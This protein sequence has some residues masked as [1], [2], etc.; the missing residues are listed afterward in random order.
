MP[1][2][3]Q[4]SKTSKVYAVFIQKT[5]PHLPFSVFCLDCA[6]KRYQILLSWSML[7]RYNNL[8]IYKCKF[9]IFH[10]TTAGVRQL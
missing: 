1:D 9:K 4:N 3:T 5:A 7:C 8:I 6:G 10:P 2:D